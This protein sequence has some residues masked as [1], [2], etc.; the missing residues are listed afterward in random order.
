MSL[1]LRRDHISHTLHPYRTAKSSLHPWERTFDNLSISIGD[2]ISTWTQISFYKKMIF[3][4]WQKLSDLAIEST[5]VGFYRPWTAND[6]FEDSFC[7][8]TPLTSYSFTRH[9]WQRPTETWPQNVY[10]CATKFLLDFRFFPI[11]LDRTCIFLQTFEC[12]TLKNFISHVSHP[13]PLHASHL[14]CLKEQK[15]LTSLSDTK[16]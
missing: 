15:T 5:V 7:L 4:Q 16:G 13:L 2:R 1:V 10:M 9:F 14:S 6:P 12:T 11:L 8:R 3:W